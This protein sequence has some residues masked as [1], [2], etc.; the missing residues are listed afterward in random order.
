MNEY[1]DRGL[2]PEQER[3]LLRFL[4]GSQKISEVLASSGPDW[5][6]EGWLV[7]SATMVD[8]TPESGK[9]SLVAS[10]AAA[11]ANGELW[12]DMPVTTDRAGPVVVISTDPS[13]KAQWANKGHDLKV[14]DDAWELITFTSERWEYY[15]D[16]AAGLDARLLVFD[17]ITSGLDGPINEADPSS[18]LGPLGRISD[19]GTPVV[20]I[21]HSAKGG[22]SGPMGPTAYMAWRRHGIHVKGNGDRRVLQ[23]AGNLGSW[24]DVVVNGKAKGAAVQYSL[25]DDQPKLGRSRSSER[26]DENAEIARWVV[27]TCQRVGVNEVA[28]RIAAEFPGVKESTRRNQ[29]L[30]GPLSKMLKH[31]GKGGSTVWSPLA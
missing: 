7:S 25:A 4:A 9:S 3:H 12:L 24:P 20:A 18:L 19:A 27:A 6:I 8:G 31:D 15:A 22:S 21:A 26:L 29:L 5:L 13:D 30:Q 16:L 14:A 2:T 28:K 1:D 11:V 10:M 23:R 17:N